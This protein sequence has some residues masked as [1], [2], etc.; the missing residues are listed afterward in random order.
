MRGLLGPGPAGT[1][2][3]E[4]EEAFLEWERRGRVR[5]GQG[6]T[7]RDEDGPDPGS[8]RH[9]R[10]RAAVPRAGVDVPP[11]NAQPESAQRQQSR[12]LSLQYREVFR[13]ENEEAFML[14]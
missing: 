14:A 12:S 8:D 6:G 11:C 5:G 2:D 13:A 7:F 10:R 4:V 3:R 9:R 1:K